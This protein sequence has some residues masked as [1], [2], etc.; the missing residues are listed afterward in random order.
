VSDGDAD[1]ADSAA[2]GD[3]AFSPATAGAELGAAFVDALA[4]GRAPLW[5]AD[6]ARTKAAVRQ[7]IDR[8]AIFTVAATLL[9]S[10]CKLLRAVQD[11]R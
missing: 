1:P 11:D 2:G 4:A 5:H 8:G 6:K 3:D 7:T 10:S 9:H